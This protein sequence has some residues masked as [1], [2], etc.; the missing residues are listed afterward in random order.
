M[1]LSFRY[2]RIC[3]FC[4]T[5]FATFS[6]ANLSKATEDTCPRDAFYVQG[7]EIS[8]EAATSA[9]ARATASALGLKK[10]WV[11]LKARLLLPDQA[12][13]GGIEADELQDLLDYT[14]IDQETVLP[15]RY[16]G[17]HDYCFDRLKTRDFFTSK[18]FRHAELRSGQMLI[19]PVWNVAGAPQLWR[20][21]NPW[22]DAW[23]AELSSRDGL[24]NLNLAST[25][26]VERAIDVAPILDGR[27]ATIAKAAK[28][29]QAERVII[30]VLTP[31]KDG[32]ELRLNVT[33]S[34]YD[35]TGKFESTVYQLEEMSLPI[36]KLGATLAWLAGDM[37]K[38]IENV[39]RTTNVVNIRDSGMLLLNIPVTSIK[40]WSERISILE[41]LAPVEDLNVMQLSKDGG[42]VRL[43][44]AGSITSLNY[45]LERHLLTLEE[46]RIEGNQVPLTLT[47]IK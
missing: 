4:I 15:G 24:V 10:A 13:A 3:I 5:V 20:R 33:A 41:S 2:T 46:S 36:A 8:G 18:S 14:R 34:L 17:R 28:L 21:P 19:L 16:I 47:L 40:E 9:E 1:F 42:V 23:E 11:I 22:A 38:G 25:L 27:R 29:E 12:D 6:W 30:T 44:M 26:S 39:W 31:T 35:R 37:A 32:D 45:A 43:N 7:I